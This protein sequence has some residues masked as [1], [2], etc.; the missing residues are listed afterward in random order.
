MTIPTI[1]ETSNTQYIQPAPIQ[2][3]NESSGSKAARIAAAIFFM[4]V[5]V[6]GVAITLNSLFIDC[7][8][9]FTSQICNIR[10]VCVPAILGS[11][12]IVGLGITCLRPRRVITP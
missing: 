1:Y 3:Q 5:G 12:A 2:S 11:I 10:F 4:G 7:D 8:P 6:T 9:Y